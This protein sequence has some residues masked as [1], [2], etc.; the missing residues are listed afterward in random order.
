MKPTM[1]EMINAA[2]ALSKSLP[3]W[4]APSGLLSIYSHRG[5]S[6]NGALFSAEAYFALKAV[7]DYFK[8]MGPNEPESRL[9]RPMMD[10]L[11]S[12]VA[13]LERMDA[14][15]VFR[16]SP[17][18]RSHDSMDNAIAIMASAGLRRTHA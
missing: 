12:A 8:T 4:L 16:R 2:V 11:R 5:E 10:A 3:N 9:V 14:P 18:N 13:N 7:D 6:D 15:G 17:G 1:P